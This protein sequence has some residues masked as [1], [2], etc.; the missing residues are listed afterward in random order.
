MFFTLDQV[1]IKNLKSV[2]GFAKTHTTSNK[3]KKFLFL[4]K[5]HFNKDRK[6]TRLEIFLR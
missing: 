6:A 4:Y 1:K 3:M 2:Q 5:S